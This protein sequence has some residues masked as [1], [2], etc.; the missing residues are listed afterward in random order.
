[1]ENNMTHR[2]IR[3]ITDLRENQH[4]SQK[5]LALES[6]TSPSTISAWLKEE[7]PQEPKI[8]GFYKV[9]KCLGVSMDYLYGEDECKAPTDNEI[10]KLTGLSG[11]AITNLKEVND[12]K[13]EHGSNE[14]ILAICNY[15]LENLDCE[16]VNSAMLFDSL[17]DYLFGEFALQ[18]NGE[19]IIPTCLVS[20]SPSGKTTNIPYSNYLLSQAQLVS[21]QDSLS[22]L[23]KSIRE[24]NNKIGQ[25]RESK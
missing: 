6:D 14:K 1:M 19:Q 20:K 17:Y 9:A 11:R 4:L 7:K 8:I 15:L 10:H 22:F 23:K 2:W 18:H 5:D 24:Q 21:V 25:E 16:E 12:K 3:R 13:N